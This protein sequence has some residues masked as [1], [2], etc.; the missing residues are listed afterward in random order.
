MGSSL[1]QMMTAVAALS[2][3]KVPKA[4]G[5]GSG[6]S[7]IPAIFSAK[8]VKVSNV[9]S[10]IN[11][12][13]NEYSG[14]LARV[15]RVWPMGLGKYLLMKLEESMLAKGGLQV[16]KVSDKKGNFVFVNGRTVGLS[17]KLND[18]EGL[19]VR[20]ARYEK[21]LAIL[22][23]KLAGKYKTS[24]KAHVAYVKPPAWQGN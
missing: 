8:N 21:T 24:N 4:E 16:D 14:V 6:A 3:V 17:N 15:R 12:L 20:M 19:A 13:V 10:K 5:I 1:G 7:S 11:G 23:A 9:A 22:T 2:G 18:F